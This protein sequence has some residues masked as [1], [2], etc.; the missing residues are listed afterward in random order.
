MKHLTY[1]FLLMVCAPLFVQAQQVVEGAAKT[2]GAVR[3]AS[4]VAAKA[5][6]NKIP[7]AV[8]KGMQIKYDNALDTYNTNPTAANYS[9]LEAARQELADLEKG[10]VKLPKKQNLPKAV[11][12]RLQPATAPS[13]S[14]VAQ[15]IQTVNKAL[16][17][18]AVRL[19]S[20]DEIEKLLEQGRVTH[21]EAIEASLANGYFVKRILRRYY[22]ETLPPAPIHHSDLYGFL[23]TAVKNG[24]LDT[25]EA[26]L[27]YQIC[28]LDSLKELVEI[29]RENGQPLEEEIL[30]AQ[31][32]KKMANALYKGD[33]KLADAYIDAGIV[34]INSPALWESSYL[35]SDKAI[36]F[37]IDRG[38]NAKV[39]VV[40]NVRVKIP[41]SHLRYPYPSKNCHEDFVY[42]TVLDQLVIDGRVHLAHYA[43]N[44]GG[45]LSIANSLGDT[46]LFDALSDPDDDGMLLMMLRE[47][48]ARAPKGQYP[49]ELH[50]K[51]AAG[52]TPYQEARHRRNKALLS[53]DFKTAKVYK[54]AMSH[55]D[56]FANWHLRFRETYLK[57]GLMELF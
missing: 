44:K 16:L 9:A 37:L 31:A 50:Y 30:V 56:E 46:P 36:M 21:L 51:N 27:P 6:G 23:Q 24:Y 25:V 28:S 18:Q 48:W 57:D 8:R 33:L 22:G 32:T 53:G 19:E 52:R 34:D 42:G 12:P 43:I 11:S 39:R 15:A 41:S 54:D 29:A 3:R 20:W 38:T 5:A 13:A 45:D 2:A 40:N 55:M 35:L 47:I 14:Q 10:I 49:A 1:V 17:E 7:G 4:T 26:I